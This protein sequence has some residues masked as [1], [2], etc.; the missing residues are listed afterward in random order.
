M[1]LKESPF[2][3]S[4][5]YI[6]ELMGSPE[7]CIE[8][9]S[10]VGKAKVREY[11]AMTTM[12][13]LP[14]ADRPLKLVGKA[15]GEFVRGNAPMTKSAIRALVIGK[16][17]IRQKDMVYDI[18]CGTGSVSVEAAFQAAYG[19]VYAFDCSDEA[20]ALTGQNRDRFFCKNIEVVKGMAPG[21]FRDCAPPDVA[22]IGG[23]K[24]RL[25]LIL[26][27]L[28]EKNEGVRVVITAITIETASEA[29]SALENEGFTGVEAELIS[30]AAVKKVGN[31]HML[32]GENPVYI[33][34]GTGDGRYG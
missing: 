5:V 1:F 12:L 31:K 34:A 10:P 22:F 6:G 30:A 25:R 28:K 18:G 26:Q 9:I 13:I 8:H 11:D 29:L 27:A 23:S 2:R 19:T 3:D 32:S 15:D 4:E 20:V 7:E 33:V 14:K 24:G 21:V 17:A 16:M